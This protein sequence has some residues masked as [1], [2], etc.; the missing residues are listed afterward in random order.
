MARP[1][2]IPS[3]TSRGLAPL[4]AVIDIGSNSVRMV[5]YTGAG[6]IS[7]PV[8]N[9]RTLCGL[10]RVMGSTGRLDPDAVSTALSHLGRF[11]TLMGAMDVSRVE[12]FATEAVRAA[13]DGAD[14]VAEAEKILGTTISILDG[15]TEAE[16]SAFGVVSGIPDAS[17]IM[18]D[19]G[20]GSLEIVALNAG[21]PGDRATLP[22]GALRLS[23]AVGAVT[24]KAG[25]IVDKALAGVSWLGA[26]KG[27]AFYPVGG[28]WR[29]FATVH[30]AQENYPLH[31]IHQY[32][33]GRSDALALLRLISRLSPSSLTKIR[34]VPKAR[35]RTLPL[36]AVVMERLLIAAQPKEVVFSA[37][38]LREGWLYRRLP[39]AERAKDPLIFAA[40][41][42]AARESRFAMPGDQ[43]D[44][45]LSAVFQDE[46]PRLRRL[47]RV[48]V[49]LSDIAW[50]DH[51]DYRARDSF[52]R[53]LHLSLT[54][55]DHRE[56]IL[57]A[58]MVSSS[59]GG[60]RTGPVR[61]L[62]LPLVD[63]DDVDHAITVGR[64]IRFARTLSAG[65]IDVL[66]T[67]RLELGK[68]QLTLHVPKGM[69]YLLSEEISRR[70]EVLARRLKRK[71]QIKD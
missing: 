2:R 32:T 53:V 17:G 48:A 29:A 36:A 55:I 43:L 37:F 9:E 5:V 8:Y 47:R 10:G 66:R 56:R 69:G 3:A 54:G 23:E 52:S 44:D 50:R 19:L 60:G 41:E 12:A 61:S 34:H 42:I 71:P 64:A 33:L 49:L 46:T 14:F 18:G 1:E 35:L 38:G 6:R 20:G 70:F 4:I 57:L 22:I 28:A 39:E 62:V 31:V 13:S 7:A 24:V 30:M 67:T 25:G 45:W 65:T 26:A 27:K 11:V 58:Y 16:T 68:S 15:A 51:P 63:A 21:K 59:Y 40:E